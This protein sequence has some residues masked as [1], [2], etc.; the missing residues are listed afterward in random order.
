[1]P[2]PRSAPRHIFPSQATCGCRAGPDTGYARRLR[3]DPGREIAVHRAR[4]GLRAGQ[5]QQP[6]HGLRR[7][8]R[9]QA[10][11]PAVTAPGQFQDVLVRVPDPRG[12]RDQLRLAAAAS[13][14]RPGPVRRGGDGAGRAGRAARARPSKQSR[15][16]P[17]AV[18]RSAGPSAAAPCAPPPPPR[19]A[20]PAP[21]PFSLAFPPAQRPSVSA[22]PPV[23]GSSRPAVPSAGPPSRPAAS[24]VMASAS[25][26]TASAA[27]AVTGMQDWR[28]NGASRQ[29][30]ETSRIPSSYPAPVALAR[31]VT[32]SPPGQSRSVTATAQCRSTFSH[33]W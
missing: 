25:A 22:L 6:G 21:P 12:D 8:R 32:R 10:V 33:C 17:P 28:G 26:I 19:A 27:P 23:P 24:R 30:E 5:A 20:A 18:S 31:H 14:A 11:L 4:Q 16:L 9:Q 3:R 1:M 2:S 13:P 7:R 29:G 15:M